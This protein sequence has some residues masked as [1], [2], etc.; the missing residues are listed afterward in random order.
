[1]RELTQGHAGLR[2]PMG[3]LGSTPR[4]SR[5]F[6]PR[7]VEG[8]VQG[9][10]R[11][12]GTCQTPGQAES[13]LIS[14]FFVY[15][16]HLPAPPGTPSS[17]RVTT[18]LLLGSQHEGSL[19]PWCRLPGMFLCE[20]GTDVSRGLKEPASLQGRRP[21]LQGQRELPQALE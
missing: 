13:E 5:G 18:T 2:K 20:C 11:A 4:L 14:L 17:P 19:A 6:L 16:L 10:C 7:S 9:L 1:M 12:G 3:A 8:P 21:R 15:V